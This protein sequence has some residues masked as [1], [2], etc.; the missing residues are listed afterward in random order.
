[1]LVGYLFRR[2]NI[3]P[4]QTPQVLNLFII[5]ISL[6]AMVLLEVP[7]ITLST[8]MLVPILLPW[9][10]TVLGAITIYIFS[11]IFEWSKETTGTL[12][13]VGVLGN[14]SFLGIPIVIY[15]YGTEA[16]PYVMIYDQLGTFLALSTYGAVVIA[17]YSDNARADVSHIIRKIFTFPPFVALIIAFG[18]HGI[19]F[20]H[21]ASDILSTLA[22]TLIPIALI[23][24]GYS[25]Q[26]K[27]PKEHISAFGLGLITKLVLLPIYAFGIVYILGLKGLSTDVSILEGAM[28]PMIT[29]GIVASLAGFSAKL[30]S[31]IIGYG[32]ILSFFTT[33]IVSWFL[34]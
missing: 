17:I 32:V 1:M 14:T 20:V 31:S 18:F 19:S 28:G 9:I 26:L 7:K 24:V 15:Y 8:D 25:L 2:F 33:A 27:I 3:F 4:E 34:G 12:L 23:S 13:L 22:H 30:S 29:A 5:Y 21:Y 6:P 16:L 10:L 11:R